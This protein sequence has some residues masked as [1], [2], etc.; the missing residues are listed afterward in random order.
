MAEFYYYHYD[1]SIEKL[2]GKIR[3]NKLL[4]SLSDNKDCENDI[5]LI[6]AMYRLVTTTNLYRK[7]D[8]SSL[9]W[10][11]IKG[12]CAIRENKETGHKT[13]IEDYKKGYNELFNYLWREKFSKTNDKKKAVK[14]FKIA[15]RNRSLINK[16]FNNNFFLL[17][18]L[19]AFLFLQKVIT[20]SFVLLE[21][22]DTQTFITT[23]LIIGFSFFPFTLALTFIRGEN[24]KYALYFF[25]F[26]AFITACGL[27]VHELFFGKYYDVYFRD[28]VTIELMK[29]NVI[30][31][32]SYL[33]WYPVIYLNN[34]R[35]ND[36]Y[37]T[38][39]N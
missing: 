38:L 22:I 13:T 34:D 12:N 35:I 9:L 14:F 2:C 18:F 36:W 33:L 30:M 3:T 26:C 5:T 7:E 32:L 28:K 25:P 29:R 39:K 21:F 11:K 10:E 6:H 8:I 1:E 27:S 37:I 23:I 20:D 4:C 31:G 16:M 19:I 24:E 17:I 15:Y